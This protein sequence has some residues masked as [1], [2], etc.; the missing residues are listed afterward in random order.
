MTVKTG[1]AWAGTFTTLDATGALA[2]PSTGPAGV[3]YVDG[4]ANAAEVTITGSNPYKFAVTLPSLTA[5]QRVDMY[6]TATIATIATAG[7]VASE[8][9]DTFIVSD[10]ETLV[11]GLETMLTDIHDTDL[12]A[13]KSDTAAILADTGTDG[14]VIAAAQTVATV[15]DV[16]NA[17][18]ISAGTGA[19][20]LDFTSGVV[21]ANLAQILGTALT[22]TAGQIAAAFKKFFNVGSPTGTVN[23]LPD[24]A[25]AANGGLPTTNGTKVNQTVDLTAGQSIAANG[26]TVT[27]LTNLPA[28]TEN[29][30]TGTGV[31]ATAV[32]KLQANLALKADLQDVED[33]IDVIATDT[34]TE[35]PAAIA[36]VPAAVW[37]YATRTLS[38]FGTLVEDIWGYVTRTLSTFGFTVATNSD[39]NVTAIKAKTD[40]IPASPAPANEYDVRMAAIQADLDNTAQYKADVSG[41]ATA[42]NLATVDGKADAIKLKTDLIPASPAPANEYDA[43]MAAI[44]ADLDNADQY[45]A[46]VS[47]IT[48]AALSASGVDAI[49][50]EVVVG[51]YTMRQLLA[52]FAAKLHGTAAGGNTD[53][54][55]YD[56]LDGTTTSVI[57]ETV[58]ED[59][60]RTVVLTV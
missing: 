57:V 3:L 20:Q 16:T 28:I 9:A 2:T 45:K 23:S 53:T 15:T 33:K 27:T 19:G 58:D 31:D 11:D 37:G 47:A 40:L 59:G 32:T 56:S 42:A 10:I 21:K 12:P 22:E 39:A 4:V 35:I 41:L 26:G 13:V 24:A 36:G 51:T 18:K 44:Q 6:I 25:P 8:Q 55:T 38:S 1:T 50:D 34:T 43:R 30:L 17:V 29:W 48:G 7:I 49:L 46:D 14:V 52:L 5:G 60:N 54:I